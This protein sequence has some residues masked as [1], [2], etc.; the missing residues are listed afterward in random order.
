MF[1]KPVL[2]EIIQDYVAILDQSWFEKKE[3]EFRKDKAYV[4]D[5]DV[6]CVIEIH[7]YPNYGENEEFLGYEE[8]EDIHEYSFREYCACYLPICEETYWG[9]SPHLYFGGARYFGEEKTKNID[10]I[11]GELV[12]DLA[13][14]LTGE[15][16]VVVIHKFISKQLE[17]IE[18]AIGE[19]KKILNNDQYESVLDDL[20]KLCTYKL[21]KRYEK[22]LIRYNEITSYEAGLKFE[23]NQNELLSLLFLIQRAGFLTYASQNE[24]L[25]FCYNH[26]LYKN[27]N[28]VS[29]R[30]TSLK[31]L[32]KKYSDINA[33]Q[34]PTSKQDLFV[35]G[36]S[37]VSQKLND[38]IK[39]LR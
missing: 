14:F 15:A 7:G 11:A 31:T 18:I 17:N 38:V 25:Q 34:A 13:R 5:R 24:L 10:E 8:T 33:S 20:L 3:L 28:G 12:N 37:T 21:Y 36:L 2:T 32:Q 9:C 6:I 27:E 26:F 1:I 35:T 29:V 30:P 39:N 22:Q 16:D 23:L 4:E 19:Q